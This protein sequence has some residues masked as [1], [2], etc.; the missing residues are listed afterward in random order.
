MAEPG[1][2]VITDRPA[3]GR[4]FEGGRRIR[5]GD[6][7][8]TGRCRLDA[9]VRYLQD[10]ARDDSADSNLTDPMT[11]VVR[12]VMLEVHVPPVF[13]EWVDVA[14]WCSGN[15]SRWAER[16]TSLH[17]SEGAHI[18][19]VTIW[20]YV[21]GE[22]G[23]PKALNPDFFEIYGPT[24]QERQVSARQAL[25]TTPAD[26][27]TVEP[28]PLRFTDFD[29]LG[30]VNNAAQWGPVEEALSRI[31]GPRRAIRAELEHGPGVDP[32]FE[33]ELRWRSADGGVDT[34]LM[35]NGKAGSVARV[36][37]L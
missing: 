31:D 29:I 12:R 18:E 24:A 33:T 1:A 10:V 4:V 7:D 9:A 3:K 11:W 32:G 17:G 6:V 15:G 28:W 22:T 25:P 16:R 37:P 36:R 5:L 2:A 27:A 13:Q 30:H 21:D 20:I 8:A 35:A 26:G 14:T 34:W 23:R 19:A